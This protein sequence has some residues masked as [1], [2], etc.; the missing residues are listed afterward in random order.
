M[1]RDSNP[2][3]RQPRPDRLLRLGGLL[4]LIAVLLP[5]LAV[6]PAWSTS[7]TVDLQGSA[8]YQRCEAYY[9]TV[10]R[11]KTEERHYLIKDVSVAFVKELKTL[12]PASENET[13]LLLECLNL[14][15]GNA[16]FAFEEIIRLEAEDDDFIEMAYIDATNNANAA[17]Y[18][19]MAE[20][21]R[22]H[23]LA[24]DVELAL[25]TYESMV[26][27]ARAMAIQ[28]GNFSFGMG[29]NSQADVSIY[30]GS[31]N[32]GLAFLQFAE[33]AIRAFQHLTS[34]GSGP[35][36]N[37][38][39]IQTAGPSPTLAPAPSPTTAP[40]TGAGQTPAATVPA[41]G[42]TL[43]GTTANTST[44]QDPNTEA[45][46]GEDTSVLVLSAPQTA[47]IT[48]L[49]TAPKL[50]ASCADYR[51]TREDVAFAEVTNTCRVPISFFWCWVKE[52]QQ[53]CAPTYLSD[54][55]MPGNKVE[56]AGPAENQTQVANF[57]VCDMINPDHICQQ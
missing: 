10:E 23:D 11:Y 3:N 24:T 4:V 45:T 34:P 56:I 55:V 31:Y 1:T 18:E 47:A 43:A 17:Q 52:R 8:V 9:L 16:V 35:A 53:S 22:K 26:N 40:G 13:L 27:E 20:V 41:G 28:R 21:E 14:A 44:A 50:D 6:K 48:A 49:P 57:V 5:A 32:A 38:G 33:L 15:N 12:E 7:G 2:R 54:V 46:A 30:G 37:S 42:V 25:E 19:Y 36:T 39:S 51:I 29:L